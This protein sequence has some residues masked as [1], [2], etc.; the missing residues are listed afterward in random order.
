[1]FVRGNTLRGNRNS[2]VYIVFYFGFN[3]ML[4]GWISNS[5]GV[6]PEAGVEPGVLFVIIKKGENV[7]CSFDYLKNLGTL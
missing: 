5:V 3:F 2:A 1:M 7:S 4:G 6:C